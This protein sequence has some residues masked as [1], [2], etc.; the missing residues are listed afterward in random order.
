M[1]VATPEDEN[2]NKDVATLVDKLTDDQLCDN[3]KLETATGE[4]PSH[5]TG[6]EEDDNINPG[7]KEKVVCEDQ[8][9]EHES[10]EGMH[11]YFLDASYLNFCQ[12]N[13][14]SLYL[15]LC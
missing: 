7:K 8:N 11:H 6:E 3:G 14:S 2:E 9:L 10:N 12:I 5:D 13:I 1:D 4:E 15:N